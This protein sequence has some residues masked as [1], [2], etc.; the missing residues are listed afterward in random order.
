[1]AKRDAR[2]N[3][4]KR[5]NQNEHK[6]RLCKV[7]IVGRCENGILETCENGILAKF[8]RQP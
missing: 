3:G 5:D 6:K 8:N 1:M 7:R 2:D 4:D